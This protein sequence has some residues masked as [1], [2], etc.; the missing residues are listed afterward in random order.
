MSWQAVTTDADP[1]VALLACDDVVSD[2]LAHSIQ[3]EGIRPGDEL[4][5]CDH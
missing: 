1:V 2:L 3:T 5:G 4:V